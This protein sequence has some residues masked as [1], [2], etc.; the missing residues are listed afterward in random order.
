MAP[1]VAAS[2]F[3]FRCLVEKHG[4]DLTFTQ[5][6]HARNLVEDAV[7]RRNHLDFC[8]STRQDFTKSQLDCIE[9]MPTI[10]QQEEEEHVPGPLIVQ[11]AGHDSDLMMQAFDVLMEEQCEFDGID[12]NLGCPQGMA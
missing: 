7:F 4:A 1:M 11:L 10:Q 2:D 8:S 6:L 9:G 12:V 5:M 3:S